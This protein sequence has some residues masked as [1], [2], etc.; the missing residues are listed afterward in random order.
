MGEDTIVDSVFELV[1]N[2]SFSFELVK[3]SVTRLENFG[4]NV[5]DSDIFLIAFSICV[6]DNLIKNKCGTLDL[7]KGL[8]DIAIDR[9]CGE[10][11]FSKKQSGYLDES[12]NLEV[13]V[14]Q[15]QTGDTN[16]TFAIE[17]SQTP[18]ERLNSLIN[19]MMTRGELEF[20]CY[21]KLKW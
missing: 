14:K 5:R 11:L 18:E 10:F 7:P 9:V 13:A 21:R 1:K 20:I 19:Y 3:D 6:V 4:Y 2:S 15:I 8:Q 16:V 17:N 12:F